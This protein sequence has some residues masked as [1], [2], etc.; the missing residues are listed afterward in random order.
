MIV[1]DGKGA[2]AFDRML[3]LS[4]ANGVEAPRRR[5]DR[6][7]CR[8]SELAVLMFTSGT[9]GSPKGVMHCLNTLLACNIALAGRFGLDASDTMLVCSPLGHMTG[10]AAGMLLGLKI[11]ASVIFQ[12]VWEPKRGV[13]I[14]AAEG[15]TYTAGAAPFLADMCEAVAGAPRPDRLRTFLCGGAPIPPVLIERVAANSTSRSVRCGA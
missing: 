13:A 7:A 2:N 5:R 6:R 15:V 12:D 4:G 9:T 14:M 3:L 1:V 8:R 11:G 10:F